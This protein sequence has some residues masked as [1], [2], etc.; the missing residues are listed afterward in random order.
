MNSSAQKKLILQ[1]DPKEV[2]YIIQNQLSNEILHFNSYTLDPY[3]SIDLELDKM[4]NAD[5]LLSTDF[6]DIEII[7][8]NNLNTLVPD[9]YFNEHVLGSYL[10][11]NVKVFPT[12]FFA[13]D[14]IVGIKAHNVYVPFVAFNNYFLDKYGAFNYK[15]IFTSLVEYTHNESKNE[16]LKIWLFKS[17]N[18]LAIIGYRNQELTF[19]NSFEIQ[20]KE[21]LI[22][23]TLFVLEQIQVNP[24]ECT[25]HLI[26]DFE[27]DD[28]YHQILYTYIQNVE[29]LDYDL[30]SKTLHCSKQQ[31]QNY[32]T[33][34]HS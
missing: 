5:E 16:P 10:Q 26:G 6:D 17:N 3:K 27:K 21:D 19:I 7:H 31:L 8:N 32:F 33:L 29:L 28:E 15:H 34:I 2:S 24:A 1:V 23:Y 20:S 22:Y 25:V 9:E 14:E 13:S 30:L 4:F 12:D 11:Y 18:V